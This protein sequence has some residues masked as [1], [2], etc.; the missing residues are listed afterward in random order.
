[1][2]LEVRLSDRPIG[3]LTRL[4]GER[5]AFFFSDA[6]LAD[7]LP[8]VLSLGF[9]DAYR[10]PR[11]P[12]LPPANKIP[13]FFA[14]L[15]PEADLRR[16]IAQRA[17]IAIANDFA[18]LWVTGADLPGAATLHDPLGRSLPPR[19]IGGPVQASPARSLLRFSLAGVQLKFS[20]I[21]NAYGGLTIRATG[22]Q[23]HWIVKLPSAHFPDI[24]ENEYAMLRFAREIGIEVPPCRLTEI[25]EIEG[26]PEEAK[27]L[28]GKC[29]AIKRFD[30]TDD[31]KRVH[32]EDFNQI[33]RQYPEDKYDNRSFAD[34]VRV[35]HRTLGNEALIDFT[36]RLVFN[37]GIANN[38]MHL[39]NWSLIYRNPCE[40][41]LAPAYD[42]VSTSLY[43]KHNETGLALGSARTFERVTLEQFAHMAGRAQAP[44][45][46]VRKT[47]NDTAER[48]RD[49][50]PRVRGDVPERVAHTI[51]EQLRLVPL[52]AKTG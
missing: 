36:R 31:G 43:L 46:L 24:P 29:L 35:I 26:L 11:S 44:A 42:Y 18:L 49:T 52:F 25:S 47:A 40:P 17:G 23:G 8:P 20:A 28:S 12:R 51:D 21:E 6:Y 39:K 1:M 13:A 4:P 27:S 34:I 32:I 22:E 10:R 16:Y 45:H 14:N 50:W 3:A 48:F 41:Q 2:S 7:P 9:L 19:A 37:M 5:T 38:D 30:R 15:L 33:F